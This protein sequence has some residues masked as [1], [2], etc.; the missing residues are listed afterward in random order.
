M[1]ITSGDLIETFPSTNNIT[2]EPLET[3]I[4]INECPYSQKTDKETQSKSVPASWISISREKR[5]RYMQKRIT[6][7]GTSIC[8][9]IFSAAIDLRTL[10][11][12][13]LSILK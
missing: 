4:H 10:L 2:V 3:T 13:L 7:L 9:Q 8:P 5:H 12:P 6:L 11:L 1:I